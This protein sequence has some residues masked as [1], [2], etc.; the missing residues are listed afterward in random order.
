MNKTIRIALSVAFLSTLIAALPRTASAQEDNSQK[1]I[2]SLEFNQA[3]V[4]E[5]IRS[6]FKNVNFSYSIAPEVQGPITA[7]LKNVTFETALQNVLRQ[8]DATYRIEAGV[9][10]IVKKRENLTPNLVNVE[11]HA[12][13]AGSS[14]SKIIRRFKFRSADP[15][16]IAMML[17]ANG[18]N[19]NYDLAPEKSTI[20]K[21]QQSGGGQ[22]GGQ[23]S[24]GFG[25]GRSG[26]NSGG[27]G[28]GNSSG[29]DS[30]GGFGG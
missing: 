15:Q 23:N 5:A 8:V 7:N 6:L 21:V 25:S 11:D 13:L 20:D 30:R 18:G 4:R 19:Q 12:R 22:N 14:T 1:Q 29:G 24:G 17:G 3:D 2:S 26:G 16:F 10:E 27:T 28:F 9:Y